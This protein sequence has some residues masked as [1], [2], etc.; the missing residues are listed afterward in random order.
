MAAEVSTMQAETTA[1]ESCSP[2]PAEACCDQA[3]MKL[4]ASERIRIAERAALYRHHNA[5]F[6]NWSLGLPAIEHS[7]L[8]QVRIYELA[9]FLTKQGAV[10]SESWVFEKLIAADQLTSAGMWLVVNMTSAGKVDLSGR[11]LEA[12]DFKPTLEGHTGGSLNMVPA[13][14]G[15][16]AANLLSATTRSWIMGQGHCVAAIEAV[17]TLIVRT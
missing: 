1:A 4:A 12:A 5:A 6:A 13:Y 3:L 15:Y 14:V 11:E 7:D 16:L 9:E 2:A 8:T 10:P 17:N